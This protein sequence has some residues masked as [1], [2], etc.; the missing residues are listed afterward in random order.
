M[1]QKDDRAILTDETS[2]HAPPE[3]ELGYHFPVFAINRSV[4][5]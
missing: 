4:Q 1:P 2:F 5:I 3:E